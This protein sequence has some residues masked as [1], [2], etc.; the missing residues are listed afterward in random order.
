MAGWANLDSFLVA[1]TCSGA[2]LIPFAQGISR[3]LVLKAPL[4]A[5]LLVY[6]RTQA[7]ATD[8]AATLPAGKATVAA[9]L[10]DAVEPA[11]IIFMCLG[12]DA[13]V[14][15]TINAFKPLHLAGKLV[16]D[17][18]TVAPETTDMVDGVLRARGGEFVAMPGKMRSIP[19]QSADAADCAF[20]PCLITMDAPVF[21]PPAMADAGQLIS[22][23][24]GPAT[25]LARLEPYMVG[26]MAR[27]SIPFADQ[28]PA[29]ALRLKL[30]GNAFVLNLVSAL[31]ETH[32]AA[33]KTGIP[34]AVMHAWFAAMYPGLVEKYSARMV[35]GDYWKREE[36]LMGVDWARK[37]AR[38]ARE[39][40]E[41]SGARLKGVQVADDYMKGVQEVMGSKG[42]L[43]GLFGAV[44]MQ[45]G[46]EFENDDGKAAKLHEPTST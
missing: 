17:C 15:S 43:A 41:R 36:P 40:A 18:S 30:V 38:H 39:L 7:R 11:D 13:A 31:A 33:E 10:A 9:S 44:R 4:T 24:A 12:D 42:D 25:C 35:E 27:Q 1:C 29:Q 3:N 6:N 28:V 23:P 16:V 5:P 34:P 22:V 37:D 19:S 21:G 20:G 8:F 14:Q 32:V 2:N 46:L 45:A 26:V